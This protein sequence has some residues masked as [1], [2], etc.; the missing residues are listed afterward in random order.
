MNKLALKCHRQG[1]KENLCN[2][3]ILSDFEF[4]LS[5]GTSGIQVQTWHI[6]NRQGT[7][8]YSVI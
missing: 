1:I 5:G 2:S 8:N 7:L 3:P 4:S 6:M